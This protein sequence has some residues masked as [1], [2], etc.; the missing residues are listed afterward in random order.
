MKGYTNRT[1][2]ENYL[3]ISIEDWFHDQIDYWIDVVE[4]FIDNFTGRNFIADT[5]ASERVFDG[6]GENNLLIDDCVE[7][8]KLEIDDEEID[9]DAYYLYPANETP[10]NEIILDDDD[11]F[12]EDHQNITITAKWGYSVA[13]P[14][15]IKQAATILT[16]LIM[17]QSL[18]HEGEIQSVQVGNFSVSYKDKKQADDFDR[19]MEIL[20]RYQKFSF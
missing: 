16:S 15:D 7:L 20:K 18:P 4:K 12:P 11:I 2:I 3:L 1:E 6:E 5:V 10:K 8:T 9:D 19:A 17:E 13:V 14:S